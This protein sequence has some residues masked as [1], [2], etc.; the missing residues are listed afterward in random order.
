MDI[1]NEIKKQYARKLTM[2]DSRRF[3]EVGEFYLESA[4]KL[5]KKDMRSSKYKL[6]LRN[7]Q[8]RLF[9]GIGCELLLKAYFLKHGY[10][11][12]KG[13]Y[14]LDSR[15]HLGYYYGH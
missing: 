1:V 2:T 15:T 14:P 6:L 11:I 9:I 13:H 5:K 8:K 12:N 4:A 7:S 3:K 10:C